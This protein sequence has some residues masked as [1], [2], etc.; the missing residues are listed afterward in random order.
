MTSQTGKYF[1]SAAIVSITGFMLSYL[2]LHIGYQ[3][4][5][6]LFLFIIA[7]LPLINF[8]PGPIFLAAV[9]S[10]FI[11]NFFFIPPYL[12]LRIGKVEDVLMFIMYFIFASV[13]GLLNS[14]IR[15]Q[16]IQINQR[17]KRTA[18]LYNLSRSLSSSKSLDDVAECS[19]KQ[20][21]ETFNARVAFLL[22]D[23]NG[24]LNAVPHPR[25]TFMID[26]AEWNIAFWVFSNSQKA[27]RF[28]NTLPITPALYYPLNSKNGNLGVA[29][30]VLPEDGGLSSEAESLLDAFLSQIS[31]AIE[32]EYLKEM[33]KKNLV[34]MESEK[35]YK[36][37]FDSITH[38]LKT[39]IT[40]IL[41]AVTSFKDD[42]ITQNKN[43][44]SK[45][46]DEINIAADRLSRLVEN[47]LDMA[48]LQSGNLRPKFEWHSVSDLI[49]STLNRIKPELSNHYVSARISDD[50]GI[51]RADYGLIEQ[52][53]VNILNNSIQ[54]TPD[55]STIIIEASRS[56][57]YCIIKISDNGPGFPKDG[58]EKI[59][60]KF[61]RAPGTKTG[62][63][64]L[65]LSIAKGFIE[66][67]GGKITARN[68]DSG[69]AEFTIL[70]PA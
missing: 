1:L 13:L 45:L 67:H 63:T 11:W 24:K 12:T 34:A 2:H 66:A 70:L 48:R 46:V 17:E 6:L 31:I 32:R 29:G 35:L 41:G 20:L 9:M 22:S 52:S 30:L 43:I 7:L 5:S 26:L 50:I 39:P 64:G 37:L 4:I 61:Y 23:D 25:S 40:T 14:R 54:Y 36:T 53:F 33:A 19:V 69:G 60:E 38:E 58:I 68:N 3:A 65:G 16:Q 44:L 55:Q 47:M 56:D 18:A 57:D 27:G 42:K 15:T 28:T 21:E 62:G 51:I 49:D 59:F 10:A 8:G